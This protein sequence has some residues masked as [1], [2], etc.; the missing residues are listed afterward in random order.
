MAEQQKTIERMCFENNALVHFPPYPIHALHR[1]HFCHHLL[2]D[3]DACKVMLT[4][5]LDVCSLRE[6]FQD[7]MRTHLLCA[8]LCSQKSVAEGAINAE[9]VHTNL[10]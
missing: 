2:R 9:S 6:Q 3:F 10:G 1:M 7:Q 8:M 4:K 5:F